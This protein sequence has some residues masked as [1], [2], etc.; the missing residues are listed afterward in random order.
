MY[1][2]PNT[3]LY[4][5]HSFVI[6]SVEEIVPLEMGQEVLNFPPKTAP[7]GGRFRSSSAGAVNGRAAVSPTGCLFFCLRHV[8]TEQK[9]RHF[10]FFCKSI[11]TRFHEISLTSAFISYF[12]GASP[13]QVSSGTSHAS[14][15]GGLSISSLRQ[16]P[17]A[18]FA[19]RALKV[20][21]RGKP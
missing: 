15:L 11:L 8:C 21:L 9:S 20:I 6:L 1:I 3:L 12:M 4:N 2:K 18:F 19:R 13:T 7:S 17:L 14:H 5:I 16:P 10:I